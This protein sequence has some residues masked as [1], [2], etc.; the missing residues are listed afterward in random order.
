MWS[1]KVCEK[2]EEEVQVQTSFYNET[3]ISLR[4]N[5]MESQNKE[6]EQRINRTSCKV[7]ELEKEILQIKRKIADSTTEM[8]NRQLTFSH[9]EY[10]ELRSNYFDKYLGNFSDKNTKFNIGC[11]V[12]TTISIIVISIERMYVFRFLVQFY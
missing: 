6:Y 1:Q 7:N 4:R 2:N 5:Y 10:N 11:L 9:S 12:L 3:N 8:K